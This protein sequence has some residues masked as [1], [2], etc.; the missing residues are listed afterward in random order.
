MQRNSKQNKW[1]SMQDDAH[2]STWH[3]AGKIRTQNLFSHS[4]SDFINR[5]WF[6]KMCEKGNKFNMVAPLMWGL[7]LKTTNLE[8]LY[9]TIEAFVPTVCVHLQ[10][11]ATY[12]IFL[13]ISAHV[14]ISNPPTC[15][16]ICL[17]KYMLYMQKKTPKRHLKIQG[18]AREFL[19][20]RA[21]IRRNAVFWFR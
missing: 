9:I 19:A 18:Q 8:S 20:S 5:H 10:H 4:L 6:M 21:L 13:L 15:I 12:T 2:E 14:L 17:T 7:H 11:V 1:G 3:K 16:C